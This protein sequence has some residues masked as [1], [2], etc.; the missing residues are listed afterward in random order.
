MNSRSFHREAL[1]PFRRHRRWAATVAP[2]QRWDRR[3][4][5]WTQSVLRGSHPHQQPSANA[6]ARGGE[7]TA[8]AAAAGRKQ[9]GGG[10]YAAWQQ[11]AIEWPGEVRRAA[12][13]A[14]H[15]AARWGR[16]ARA[17]GRADG[18]RGWHGMPARWRGVEGENWPQRRSP[19]PP[20]V[21]SCC[22]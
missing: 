18:H 2:L 21:P 17:A 10:A 3:R 9:Y 12:R 5:A 8:A 15:W 22:W 20:A 16:E 4:A 7:A 1:T 6:T 14:E 13:P 11:M 19:R